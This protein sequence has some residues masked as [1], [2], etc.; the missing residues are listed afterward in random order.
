MTIRAEQI[1]FVEFGFDLL[2]VRRSPMGQAELFL[3]IRPVA[4]Q[5]YREAIPV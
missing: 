4:D 2:E 5:A 1:A 3:G